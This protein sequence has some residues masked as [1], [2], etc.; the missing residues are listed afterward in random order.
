ML[1]RSISKFC[2]HLILCTHLVYFEIFRQSEELDR[3]AVA[4]IPDGVY[5]AEGYLDND[6]LTDEPRRLKV[7]ICI[8]GEVM[9]IDLSG[10]SR[11]GSGPINC[12]RAQTIAA[13]RV[14]YKQII[15]PESQVSGG[16][17][18]NLEVVVEKGTFLAAEEPAP[19]GWY[20]TRSEER[21]VGKECRL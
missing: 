12:G 6:G 18:Q 8:Q 14:G 7:K 15:N 3:K 4:D 19:C 21:R 2:L 1:F 17:F 13:C 11:M 20:F 16:T 9:K 5:E 10:S